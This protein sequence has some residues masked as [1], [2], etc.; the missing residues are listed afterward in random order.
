MAIKQPKNVQRGKLY[1]PYGIEI[2]CLRPDQTTN[3][4]VV[5]YLTDGNCTL[6]FSLMKREYFVPV[7]VLLKA[8]INT[9]DREI[10]EKLTL[11]DEG[12]TFLTDRVELLLREAKQFSVSSPAQAYAFLGE[13][14]R[15]SL[16]A[17]ARHSDKMV[18][19]NIWT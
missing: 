3:R 14:F 5:H 1:S 9:T 15:N 7:V 19:E 11:G 4:N 18:G 16:R 13:R 10:Y 17:P 6:R 8:F 12:N 2:R